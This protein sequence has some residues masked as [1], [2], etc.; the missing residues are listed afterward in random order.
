MARGDVSP[1]GT[2][3]PTEAPGGSVP[4][5]P[6]RVFRIEVGL[7]PGQ[8]DPRGEGVAHT[9]E[10]FLGIRAERVRTRDVYLVEADLTE[11]EA[12]RFARE[13]SDPVRE[14]AGLGKLEDGKFGFAV[15]VAYKAG[16]TDPVGKSARIAIE[17]T[18]GRKLDPDAAV[19]TSVLY[20]LDGLS[21]DEAGRV[22]WDL[23]ANPL[24]HDVEIRSHAEWSS[25]PP[26]L[27]VPRIAGHE[28]PA[29]A[30]IDLAGSDAELA[31]LSRSRLLS[32]T[33]PEM[34]AVRDHFVG[35]AADPER[36]RHGLGAEPTDA[37]LECIAQTW[38]EHCKHKIFHATITYHEHGRSSETIRSLFRTYIRGATEE[39]DRQIRSIEGD[40][41]LV[42]VFH[43]NAGVVAFD[44]VSHLVHKVETHNSPSALDPYGGAITG[45]VGVNRD[46]FGTGLG[47]DLLVNVWG[48][49]FASPFVSG[50]IPEGLLHPRRIRDGVHRGV[51]DGGNQS[52]IP[53]GRGF[54]IF[55]GRYL[56]KPLVFCGT[57]AAL[58]VRIAGRPGHE[59]RARPGDRIVMVGGRVGA[60]GI[61]GATFS[62]A[63]LTETTPVQ[64]VQIGDPITQ[65]RM[66]DFLLEARN[67]DLYTSITDNGAGGLSSSVGEMARDPGGARLDLSRAPL[68]YPG[69]AP[70]EVLVSESQER[71]TVAVPAESDEAFLRLAARREVEATVLG[72]FTGSGRFHVTWGAETVAYL[73]MEFL[74]EGAPDLGLVA[75]WKPPLHLEPKGLPPEDLG[76][77][78]RALAGR[79]NLCSGEAR[80]RFY[81]HEVK[82]LTVIK[83]FV[84][85]RADVPSEA[86]V[87]LIRHGGI[88]GFVLSEGVNPFLSDID[89]YAMA[90][91]AL[92]EAV[93]RQICAGARL[94]RIAILD[95]FCWPD[96]VESETTPDGGY[97]L[98]QLVRACRG[99]F[100]LARAYGT[101]LISG[102]DSM[103]ND[104]VKGGVKIGVPPTLLVSALGQIEDVRK[105]VTLDLKA[106]GDAV[107]V[108]GTTRDETGGSEYF[109]LRGEM[110]GLVQALGAPCPYVGNKVPE[111]RPQDSLPLYRALEG[112]IR[113][114][115]VRSAA[116]VTKGGLGMAFARSAM[117]GELGMELSFDGCSDLTE[118]DPDVALF[119][120]SNGRFVVT[121][122]AADASAFMARFRGLAL[123]RI[124]RVTAEPRLRVHVRGR[125]MV[126]V[127]VLELTAGWKE[128]L[129]DVGGGCGPPRRFPRAAGSRE[130]AEAGG[131]AR[132]DPHGARPQ[133]RGGD[134][135]G[136]PDRGRAAGARAPPRLPRRDRG[137][138]A[139]G[140]PRARVRRRVRVRRPHGGGLRLREQDPVAYVRR[141]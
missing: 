137:T 79:L 8:R 138:S 46:S 7:V 38:S 101:P 77:V 76:E 133:L 115:L 68:K 94:D 82:G 49:C 140:L 120:E 5:G 1:S 67:L 43:D 93:R 31:E 114:G 9:A 139:R 21:R 42:S 109:R 78:L 28:R 102:K 56:G 27:T 112:A 121:T 69:L 72:E 66:F 73:P 61:H 122:S 63:A 48:Y 10:R 125:R 70:W 11:D 111:V 29:V 45:I 23:L 89:P 6:L 54:E 86:T 98:G 55:D 36:A 129:R 30:R 58:P 119:S 50:G 12:A 71:M 51:I 25:S 97:K 44:D 117:A 26:D 57:V 34:R 47:A 85:A 17:D 110:D 131:G 19:Y 60:D 84:G 75:R 91:A 52:G 116:A 128:T 65:K 92:D 113:D 33:L 83:P 18:L 13:V 136:V 3:I 118:L 64:V 15:R 80:A 20:L 41:W 37:E 135:S 124:G 40:S 96:P 123:K 88:R 95:N 22:A 106:A 141:P 103:K 100:D 87:F 108:L 53:Y 4:G 2:P 32:L 107:F 130:G 99:L 126:D 104:S 14:R 62:S 74:H 35:Q 134:R 59:K 81:D 132:P 105:A 16:V 127:D 39:I 90:G 24:I